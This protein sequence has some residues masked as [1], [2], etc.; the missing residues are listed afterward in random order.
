[1]ESVALFRLPGDRH[2]TRLVSSRPPKILPSLDIIRQESGFLIAPFHQSDDCPAVLIQPD[3]IT[4]TLLPEDTDA[5]KTAISA[6]PQIPPSYRED[7]TRFHGAVR[8]GQFSKLVLAHSVE[9]SCTVSEDDLKQLFIRTCLQ[10]PDFMV[11][12]FSTPQTGLW[13]IASPEV[14]IEGHDTTWHTMAMAGTTANCASDI[15]WSDK[16][17]EEQMLVERFVRDTLEHFASDISTDGPKTFPAGHLKHLRTDFSFSIEAS[18]LGELVSTLHPTPAVSGLPRNDAVRFILEH[19]HLERTYYSGFCGPLNLHG[20]THLYV[21]L[22]CAKLDTASRKAVLYAGGGLMP[23]S[24]CQEEWT[25]IW[26]K[27]QTI[28]NVL[29]HVQ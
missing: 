29:H 8:D 20:E 15:P 4:I 2:Y 11:I 28:N 17:R 26:Q 16:N 22:R 3:D 13:L 23:Q 10:Y 1:M 9:Q 12:L 6:A 19:E 18:R 14:L 24:Q 7:F 21:S 25:E 5:H 27:M